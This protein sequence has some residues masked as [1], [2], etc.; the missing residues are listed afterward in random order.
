MSPLKQNGK[1]ETGKFKDKLPWITRRNNLLIKRSDRV[2]K[3]K[4]LTNHHED[5]T[6][7]NE[8]KKEARRAYWSYIEGTLTHDETEES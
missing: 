8:L 1:L 3:N 5:K 2:Y 7:Y 6:K 4:K